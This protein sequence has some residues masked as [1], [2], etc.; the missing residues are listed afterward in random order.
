MAVTDE[1]ASSG[2]RRHRSKT[3]LSWRGLWRSPYARGLVYQVV[4]AVAV[5]AIVAFLTNNAMRSMA[6]RGMQTGLGFLFGEAGFTL[7]ESVLPFSPSD[8]ML[9]A[10]AAGL[11]NTLWIS[12]FSV[13]FATFLGLLLGIARLS[14][15]TLVSH[16]ATVYVEVFRNTPQLIQIVFWYT[17]S[18]LLPGARQAW[19]LG[20]WAFLSNRGVVLA[21]PENQMAF[22]IILAVMAAGLI[23]AFF[24][25]R[26]ADRRQ[27][28]TGKSMPVMT[29]S[30][31]G[32]VA[33]AFI[34]WLILGAPT[35]VSFPEMKG[36][37]FH[38]GIGL[39]PEFL[40]LSL[41]LVLYF[42]AYIAE[43]VRSGIQSV[44]KGQIEAGRAV[45]LRGVELYRRIILPQA[46]RVIVPP[47]TAQYISLLKT[48]ALGVAVGYPELFNVSNTIMTVSGQTL[49]CVMIMGVVYLIMALLISSVM[50]VFNRMVALRGAKAR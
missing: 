33:L 45:G 23:P 16:I 6:A 48:S 5:V 22:G 20:N 36:F 37:N 34:A 9:M 44:S 11:S 30:V 19:H 31:A 41:G 28:L 42:A 47:V 17:L 32:I 29:I 2:R 8:S 18:T 24:Y 12:F 40:S 26:W 7:A 14:S 15:N 21:W 50:N 27:R 35:T 1:T 38:G 49:E 46:L 10:F 43:I 4:A 3:P 25:S 13:I 39:S